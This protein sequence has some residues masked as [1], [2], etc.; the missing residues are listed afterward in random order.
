MFAIGYQGERLG[1]FTVRSK[2]HP[3]TAL[4]PPAP[5]V[6]ASPRSS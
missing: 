3:S 1:G 2:N 5:K 4:A 6:I